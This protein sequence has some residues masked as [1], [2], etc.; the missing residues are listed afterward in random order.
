MRQGL[1]DGWLEPGEEF[2]PPP[3]IVER[4]I[5][6]TTG[7]L[8]GP[9]AERTIMEEFIEGTEP[10]TR[11]DRDWARTIRLPWYLQEPFY[12]PKEGEKMPAQVADWEPIVDGWKEK[13]KRATGQTDDDG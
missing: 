7:L 9:G 13:E 10:I 12:V 5:E 1:E 2:V 6:P 11:F 4:E 8:F 3:G